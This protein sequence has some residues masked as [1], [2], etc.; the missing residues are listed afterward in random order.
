MTHR[1]N[2]T[3]FNPFRKALSAGHPLI[4]VWSMLNS[5][6]AVEGLAWAGFDWLLIDGEH[7]PVTLAD[8]MAH[9]RVLAGTPTIPIVRLAWNDP[10]LLKRY[11]DAG[12][13][14]IMLPYVQNAEEASQ[15]VRAMRYPPRG[16]RGVAAMHRASRYGRLRNYVGEADDTLFLIVQIETREALAQ[17]EDICA[18][19][20]VDAVFFGPGDLAASMGMPGNPGHPSVTEA[21]SQ[22]LAVARRCGKVAGAL[23]PN[24]DIAECHLR[25]GFD[26]VSVANDCAMLFGAADASAARFRAVA[27][28]QPV[29]IAT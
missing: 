13:A 27:D 7:A 28:T 6:N 24:T 26:F 12:A 19:D 22:G 16:D 8:A 11:L 20:G 5:T 25:A 1:Q 21:I 10:V 4:G 29:S 3:L 2:N 18:V 14:T 15:A 23:A 17:L 9:M